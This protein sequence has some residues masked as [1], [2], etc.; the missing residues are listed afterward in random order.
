MTVLELSVPGMGCRRCVREAT[1]RLRDVPGVQTVTADVA[2]RRITLTGSMSADK[3][4]ASL[5]GTSYRPRLL[6]GP[7]VDAGEATPPQ[8]R[9]CDDVEDTA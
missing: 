5:A 3:A 9:D 7:E 6:A 2:R 8:S 4:L 1:A